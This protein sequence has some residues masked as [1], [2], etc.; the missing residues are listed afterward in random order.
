[1]RGI[2]P[3]PEQERAILSPGNLLV[4]AGAG[5][6]KTEVL[7]RRF[8]ALIA[9]DIEGAQPL[10]PEQIAAITFTEKAT[11]DMRERIALVLEERITKEPP[12]E[13]L[14]HLVRARRLLP[15][16]HISTIHAFCQRIL[17]ENPLEAGLA[18]GFEV[19][20][21]YESG[22]Y[23]ERVCEQALV[24]AVRRN[25]AGALR[26]MGARGMRGGIYREGALDI[27]MRIVGELER[28][29]YPPEWIVEATVAG[30]RRC[31][32]SHGNINELAHRLAALVDELLNARDLPPGAVSKVSALCNQWPEMRQRLVAIE[33]T[34][35][36]APRPLMSSA[37]SAPRSL[38]RAGASRNASSPSANWQRRTVDASGSR[39]H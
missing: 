9:G 35:D 23:R 25:D 6:G 17:A 38:V 12:G 29:S 24:D 8:V 3:S 2:A 32:D 18:P 21:E 1:M 36:P 16:A 33:E 27:L 7:A 20:D 13:R 4:R 37:K 22:A 10:A 34:S 11:Y 19:I 26:L 28:F 39:A 15:L 14:T 30:V 31:A 5:S